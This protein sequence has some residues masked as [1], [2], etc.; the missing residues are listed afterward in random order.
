MSFAD[1]QLGHEAT[2][3]S[4]NNQSSNPSASSLKNAIMSFIVRPFRKRSDRTPQRRVK[5]DN[6]LQ[7]QKE[8]R[9]TFNSA[10]DLTTE[11]FG[12]LT[13]EDLFD[14]HRLVRMRALTDTSGIFESTFKGQYLENSPI[15]DDVSLKSLSSVT[16]LE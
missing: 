1:E 12:T 10:P 8:K 9:K 16:K 15:R 5:S 13:L 6:K 2:G 7:T 14:S 3:Q 11:S 4:L